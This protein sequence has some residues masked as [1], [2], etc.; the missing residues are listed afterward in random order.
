MYS[1]SG[2][3]LRKERLDDEI[4]QSLG[5]LESFLERSSYSWYDSFLYFLYNRGN[6]ENSKTL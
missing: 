2:R 1:Y 6:F 3:L 5:L 4:F